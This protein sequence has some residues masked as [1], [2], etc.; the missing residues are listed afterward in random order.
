MKRTFTPH[1]SNAA[2]DIE[3]SRALTAENANLR[4]KLTEAEACIE[5]LTREKS[6]PV[7]RMNSEAFRLKA[8]SPCYTHCPTFKK[9]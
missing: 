1:F 3:Q 7:N 5:R 6:E 2:R 8:Q 9:P 4:A